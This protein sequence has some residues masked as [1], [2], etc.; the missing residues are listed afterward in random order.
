VLL[1]EDNEFN[2]IIATELLGD[3]AGM[4]VTLAENGREA[5]DHLHATHFDAVLM[6]VQMPVMDGYEATANI[7]AHSKFASLPVIAMTAHAMLGYRQKCLAAGMNDYVTKPFEP[8]ELFAV[9]LKWMPDADSAPADIA[10]R[11]APTPVASI[12][13]EL[14]LKRCLG[15]A[16]LYERVLRRFMETRL[17]DARSMQAA[18]AARDLALAASIAHSA[19]STAGAIGAQGLSEAARRLEEALSARAEIRVPDLL[20]AFARCHEEVLDELSRHIGSAARV[21]R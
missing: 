18:V 16:D 19:I 7:R 8:A 1:V 15:R 10:P 9:L 13:F 5:L 17:D 12:S 14:G 20:D 6:D 21:D 2:Q 3:V 4:H 11:A